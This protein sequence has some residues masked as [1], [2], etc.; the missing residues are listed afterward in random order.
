MA[1]AIATQKA[2]KVIRPDWTFTGPNRSNNVPSAMRTKMVDATAA[3]PAFAMMSL[4][5]VPG[6]Q[7]QSA[8]TP[9]R[10]CIFSSAVPLAKMSCGTGLQSVGLVS[11]FLPYWQYALP[12]LSDLYFR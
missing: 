12:V 11:S 5:S 4:H 8:S 2:P 1:A 3:T 7:T 6:V 9:G 10:Y